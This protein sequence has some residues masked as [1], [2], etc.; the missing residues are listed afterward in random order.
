M[1]AAVLEIGTFPA[2]LEISGWAGADH[3]NKTLEKVDETANAKGFY[4]D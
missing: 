3:K 1:F 2:L 4:P